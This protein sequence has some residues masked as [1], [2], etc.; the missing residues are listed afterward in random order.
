MDVAL[1]VA[2]AI[3]FAVVVGTALWLR[4]RCPGEP[5]HNLLATS[6]S[7]YL[8]ASADDDISWQ[9]WGDEAFAMEPDLLR[10]VAVGF[11]ACHK[12]GTKP[13]K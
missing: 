12:Q 3:A 10:F 8:R 4:R 5:P 2:V 6:A 1:L 7:T 13:C 11:A 9:P